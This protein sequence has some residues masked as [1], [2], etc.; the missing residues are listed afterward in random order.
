LINSS[1]NNS[2]LVREK[3]LSYRGRK[4]GRT[5]SKTK[6]DI[7]NRVKKTNSITVENIFSKNIFTSSYFP[8][9]LEIGCGSGEFI[10]S[11]AIESPEKGFLV[12]EQ[13]INGLASLSSKISKNNLKN[14]KF[15][16][17]DITKIFHLLPHNAFDS[18]YILF[19][20]PWPKSRHHKRRIIQKE[21][22]DIFSKLLINNGILWF[23]SDDREYCRFALLHFQNHP[24]FKWAAEKRE[25]W[26][27][28]P[29]IW[30]DTRYEIKAKKRG[31][32]PIFLKFIKT[33]HL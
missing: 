10:V 8:L 18:I 27:K 29:I 2:I 16:P 30:A 25:D 13:Y 6:S 22:I 24:S 19:P 15:F 1:N 23:A 14:I 28:K 7:L 31:I 33:K 21:I 20:D 9:S 5:L 26:L 17:G 12:V 11:Q 4:F 3:L 32:S